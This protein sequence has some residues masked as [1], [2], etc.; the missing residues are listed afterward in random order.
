ML[1]D[2]YAVSNHYGSLAFG[3]YTAYCKNFETGKWYDFNDSSVSEVYNPNEVV[4]GAAYVLYYIRKDFYPD[5]DIDYAAIKKVI[6]NPDL[7]A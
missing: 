3:H 4:S 2:L 6:D 1:Y 5:G 7:M